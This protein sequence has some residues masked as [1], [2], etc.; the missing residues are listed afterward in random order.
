MADSYDTEED[1]ILQSA[2]LDEAWPLIEAFSSI[3]R[4]HPS[5]VNRAGR[6]IAERLSAHGIPV[7][8]HEPDLY[9]S[10]PGA[11]SVR[12]G[13]A[14]LRAKPPA[15][16]A[17]CPQGVS[18]R[19]LLVTASSAKPEGYGP[20]SAGLFGAEYDPTPGLGAVAGCIALYRGTLSV[21][22][23]SQLEDL[24]AAAVVA[25]N[26]GADIHWGACNPVWGT[27]D[28]D[29]LEQRPR[30][31]SVAVNRPD[32]DRL[33]A[34]A[35]AGQSA[36]IETSLEEG[37][38]R[39]LLPVVEIPGQDKSGDF[40]LLH[41]H[42]NSWAVGVGD[43]ATGN[44]T[45]LEIARVLWEHRASLRRSVR[46]AWWPGH[47]T[48][49]FA[50]STWYADHFAQEIARSCVLHLNCD[51]PGCRWATV[52]ENIPWM[53]ENAGFVHDVVRKATGQEATGKRPTQTSDYS[54]NNIG[55][56]GCFSSS[57]RM[58]K[59]A[60]EEHGYYFVM[61]N[62]GNIEWH[63]ERDQLHV[64][65]REV[66]LADIRVYLLAVLRAAN[67]P[68]LPLDFRALAAEFSATLAAYQ[69]AAGEAFDLTPAANSLARLAASLARL[70]IAIAENRIKD[71]EA[72]GIL[73][74]LSRLLVP[75]NYT[76]GTRFIHDP[77]VPTPALP[78]LAGARNLHRYP[79]QTL[80]FAQTQMLRGMNHVV[81]ALDEATETV[82]A[83]VG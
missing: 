54:F 67:A 79:P 7:T 20:A 42:Y 65:D 58:P 44:A 38:F 12:L 35:A 71:R 36:R 39:S 5:E 60:L 77:G 51:S 81:A 15:F 72:N 53:A 9:L 52:Y 49:K 83:V 82:D 63:T 47:S 26:P 62:G 78:M 28:L 32:G 76:R 40:V 25:I 13:D 29:Q 68:V 50:G 74:R 30:I 59:S 14:V 80:G 27:P 6:L 22:R 61:G 3:V 1:T 10:L 34:A 11:A 64:A 70:Q 46:I 69:K 8:L 48:G 24:G 2:G 33:I 31:P 43:N 57:S 66:L 55:V 16:S 37:W 17:S 41:G 75:L 19:L 23:I 56:S 21:E 73:L 45:M 4:E 18:G